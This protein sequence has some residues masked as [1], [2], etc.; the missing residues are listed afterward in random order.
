M[1]I[2]EPCHSNPAP[3]SAPTPSP[4]RSAKAA[5]GRCIGNRAPPSIAENDKVLL[6]EGAP[7][8]VEAW[9]TVAKMVNSGVGPTPVKFKVVSGN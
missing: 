2:P 9:K 3:P 4:P 7:K 1:L 8:T 6:S 5:W